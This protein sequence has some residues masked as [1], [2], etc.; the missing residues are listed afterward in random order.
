MS[1]QLIIIVVYFALTVAIGVY[2]MKKASGADSFTGAGLGVLMCVTAGTGEWLGGTSTTGVSEYGFNAGISGAWYTIA[3]GIGVCFLAIFFAKL[4]RS[5]ET[6]TVPGIVEKFIGVDARTVSSIILTFV[7]IAVG[8]SQIV[9]AGTLGVKVLNLPYATSVII[10]SIGF[11]IYTLCGGMNA[12]AYTNTMHLAAMY[13]GIILALVFVGDF[14]GGWGTLG[15]QLSEVAAFDAAAKTAETGVEVAP[16]NFWGP[17]DIGTSKVFSW[18][19]ASLLGA[20][21]AQAGIQP[22]LAAKDV[23]TARKAAFIT[24][25]VVA[26]F[27]IFTAMLGMAAKAM[28]GNPASPHY[29]A[30]INGKLALPALMM[31]LHP[32]IGGIVLSSILAAILSTVSPIILAAGT[33]VTKDIYQRKIKPTATDKE[34]IFMSRLTTAIAGILCMILAL[35]LYGTAAILDMVYFAY[36]LRGAMFVI[37]LFAIYWKKTSHKGSVWA[38]ICTAA[39]GCFWV[40][41]KSIVGQFP[42]SPA[43]TE[44][45]AGVIAAFITTILFTYLM[46]NPVDKEAK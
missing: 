39:V 11:I 7:M 9:A 29:D 43:F 30:A 4:Y 23:A 24:A 31:D 16:V 19:L 15:S 13:G 10:M 33:M 26:P 1:T 14:I 38:M 41:Y 2:S 8:T 37:L 36:S 6:V 21:T 34:V 18:I 46:P 5:L 42:I 28:Y 27:G 3:N 32:V 35:F 40:I 25:I 45:Y 17:F 44:T 20:C 22:I 12:V